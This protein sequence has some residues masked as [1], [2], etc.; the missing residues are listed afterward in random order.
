ML[1]RTLKY[2]KEW[3]CLQN[4]GFHRLKS[5]QPYSK[6]QEKFESHENSNEGPLL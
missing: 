1:L 6:E 4:N 5:I 2:G 3:V